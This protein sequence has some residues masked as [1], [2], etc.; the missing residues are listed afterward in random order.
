MEAA[1]AEITKKTDGRVNFKFYPGG[2][3]GDGDTILRKMMIGQLQGGAMMAG[4]LENV[5]SGIR[6]YHMPLMFRSYEEVD[7]V[8]GRMD[9]VI[10]EEL[11]KQGFV[12]LGLAE[13]GF[14]YLMSK[15]PINTVEELRRHKVWIPSGSTAAEETVKTFD[16]NPI[17]LSTPDVRTGLQTGMIDTIATPPIGAIALQWHTQINYLLDL[18]LI[19]LYGMLVVSGKTFNKLTPQDQ[20][21]L[22]DI[23]GAT[24]RDINQENRRDNTAAL[25]ALKNQGINIIEA[26]GTHL[27]DWRALAATT[28][29]RLVKQGNLPENLLKTIDGLLTEY[30]RQNP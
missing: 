14:A 7:F 6:I 21:I 19:Y 24:I 10:V 8:R 15:A 29:P 25:A 26:D 12:I 5:Y 16:V 28:G 9:A 23:M 27:E 20:G 11:E 22:R 2:V 1:A 30:R 17:P 4:A 18:P 13:A 3:M